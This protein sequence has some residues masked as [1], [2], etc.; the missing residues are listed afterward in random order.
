ML[1]WKKICMIKS[2]FTGNVTWEGLGKIGPT[3][4][5]PPSQ[6]KNSSFRERGERGDE[7]QIIRLMCSCMKSNMWCLRVTHMLEG[8]YLRDIGLTSQKLLL[9]FFRITSNQSVYQWD[10]DTQTPHS[11]CDVPTSHMK[12]APIEPTKPILS[13]LPPLSRLSFSQQQPTEV[14]SCLILSH[15]C[16]CRRPYIKTQP[17]EPA[18]ILFPSPFSHVQ[19]PG[20]PGLVQGYEMV[21]LKPVRQ[22]KGPLE[23]E[24]VGEQDL[25]DNG[26]QHDSKGRN[27]KEDKALHFSGFVC[28]FELQAR[29]FQWQRSRWCVF[30]LL[31][32]FRVRDSQREVSPF[33]A[34]DGRRNLQ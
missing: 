15:G 6:N 17:T 25:E 14:I 2:N 28:V 29:E 20:V 26:D 11:N 18:E 13:P 10:V 3:I 7:F 24:E 32:I 19:V 12:L 16:N 23:K 33:V 5:L 31:C 4:F 22:R 34:V 1:K 9:L 8:C 21:K 27:Q 30:L